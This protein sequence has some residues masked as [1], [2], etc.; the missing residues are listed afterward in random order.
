M[1]STI[2]VPALMSAAAKVRK[3]NAIIDGLNLDD[4]AGARANLEVALTEL[5]LAIDARTVEPDMP[6]VNDEPEPAAARKPRSR[7]QKEATTA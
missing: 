7:K 4:L 2:V 3:A 1:T 5:R 6:T